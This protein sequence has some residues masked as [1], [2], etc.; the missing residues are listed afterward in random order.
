[1]STYEKTI[2]SMSE[3]KTMSSHLTSLGKIKIASE[4]GRLNSAIE[5]L[6]R[7]LQYAHANSKHKSTPISLA[8]GSSQEIQAIIN[9]C[10]SAIGTK[11][12]EW[13]ILAERNGW[14][15]PKA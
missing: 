7:E 1:M 9:Y 4:D 8:S 12:P 5:N 13:Q 11:K 14:T 15:P 2:K 10:K 6:I 3:V